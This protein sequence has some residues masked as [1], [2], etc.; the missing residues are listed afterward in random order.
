M[1]QTDIGGICVVWM[2]ACIWW[3]MSF[4]SYR[5][6]A[7]GRVIGQRERKVKGCQAIVSLHLPSPSL[8]CVCASKF[9]ISVSF[10]NSLQFPLHFIFSLHFWRLY[11]S[12]TTSSPSRVSKSILLNLLSRWQIPHHSCE[13]Q[14]AHVHAHTQSTWHGNATT[15]LI[16]DRHKTY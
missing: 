2:F 13:Q 5:K 6:D 1:Y 4:P 14:S 10:H 7:R 3:A 9:S 11:A 12:Q 15:F 16:E 8:R